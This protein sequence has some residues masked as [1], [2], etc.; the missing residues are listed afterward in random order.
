MA[1]Y[2]INA[3]GVAELRALAGKLHTE[4]DSVLDAAEAL[5]I[6]ISVIGSDLGKYEAEIS[7][8][9]E[10]NRKAI[11]Q[12]WENI[13]ALAQ[14]VLQQADKVEALLPASA[15]SS[16][17]A[18]GSSSGAVSCVIPFFPSE[19]SPRDLA[20][21]QF[22]FVADSDGNQVYD[23]PMETDLFMYKSQGSAN[24]DFQGTCGLCSCANI[25][26]LA[27][28]FASEAE[29]IAYASQAKQA[30]LFGGKLC[31]TGY[32]DPA[33]N[34]GT[35]P[36]DRQQILS[37]FGI[38]SGIFPIE[39]ED[40]GGLAEINIARIADYVSQGRGVILQV[41][42]DVLWHDAAFGEND[43]HAVTVTSVKK[44]CSG[45]V[46]GFYICDSADGHT[47]YYP[48]AKVLRS[49]T[50]APMNVTYSIIR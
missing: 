13:T 23:S 26:R 40:D 8:L 36:K 1:K 5:Q 41:H 2:A 9:V 21:T 45:D 29:M 38:D 37:H 12:N 50:G 6:T 34:G 3:R 42:A 24:P 48:S 14:K 19:T 44:S 11:R 17:S 35:C 25:L 15:R 10:L 27:G 16:G 46:L 31:T 20:V 32:S 39:F 18:L 7:E 49:L 30:G 43:S 22:G 47:T 33:L 4:A 28:I